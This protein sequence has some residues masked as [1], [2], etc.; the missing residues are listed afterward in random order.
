MPRNHISLI[1]TLLEH[2]NKHLNLHICIVSSNSDCELTE[3]FYVRHVLC[4]SDVK[5]YGI[6]YLYILYFYLHYDPTD[7]KSAAGNFLLSYT[8]GIPRYP[9]SSASFS[10]LSSFL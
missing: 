6:R 5:K 1:G 2:F 3:K 8:Q 7:D 10:K 4:L 9:K